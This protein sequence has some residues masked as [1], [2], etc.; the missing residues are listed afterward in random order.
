MSFISSVPIKNDPGQG[1]D[2]ST[3]QKGGSRSGLFIF[4]LL[5]LVSLAAGLEKAIMNE[6]DAGI[7]EVVIGP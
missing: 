6:R 7:F 2:G 5:V 4:V 1:P 3:R